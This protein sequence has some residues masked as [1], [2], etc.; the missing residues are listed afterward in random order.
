MKLESVQ[1]KNFRMLQDFKMD[2]EDVLTLIIGKNNSGK[3]SFLS[4]LQKFLSGSEPEFSFEDFN[5]QAQKDILGCEGTAKSPKE[6][7]ELALSLK[8][9][10]SYTDTDSLSDVADLILDLD[11]TKRHLVILFEYVLTYEKYQKLVSD[12][13]EYK[14]KGIERGFEYFVSK[15]IKKYFS[16]RIRALEYKNETNSKII[17]LDTVK[18]AISMQVIGAKRDVDNEQGR[19]HSLSLL[20]DKYYHA[21]VLSEEEFPELQRQLQETDNN[22]SKYIKRFLRKSLKKS[23][24]CHIILGRQSLQLSQH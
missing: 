9:Y 16:T 10:I 24:G 12:Y 15:N 21:S 4:I 3:T 2:L 14:S 22:L 17:S 20:A 1:I 5:I 8:L 13:N 19:S 18:A 7:L 6:Y 11:E 23:Q